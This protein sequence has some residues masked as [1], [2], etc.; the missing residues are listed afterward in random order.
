MCFDE[1]AEVRVEIEKALRFDTTALI[2]RL[3]RAQ[4][5]SIA[6]CLEALADDANDSRGDLK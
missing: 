2:S 4:K 3:T 1:A 5:K 6:F